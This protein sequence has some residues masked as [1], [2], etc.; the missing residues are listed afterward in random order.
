M[1]RTELEILIRR[2]FLTGHIET[3]GLC[4]GREFIF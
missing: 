2:H 4:S 3:C 1:N